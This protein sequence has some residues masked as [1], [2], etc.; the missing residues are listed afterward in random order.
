MTPWELGVADDVEFDV[1]QLS[2]MCPKNW[3]ALNERF[4]FGETLVVALADAWYGTDSAR[5]VKV[6]PPGR[7]NRAYTLPSEHVPGAEW[8][9]N[10]NQ[11]AK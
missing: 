11:E 8:L 4:L 9:V 1:M 6:R 5:C 2:L 10:G 7:Y 3:A